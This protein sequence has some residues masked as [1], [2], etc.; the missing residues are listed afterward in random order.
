M[1]EIQSSDFQITGIELQDP[2]SKKPFD[3]P[4]QNFQLVSDDLE[5]K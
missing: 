4:T 5:F 2:Q 3:G 1:V